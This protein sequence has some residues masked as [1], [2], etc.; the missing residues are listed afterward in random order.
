[1]K[2]RKKIFAALAACALVLT[3]CSNDSAEDTD[4]TQGDTQA[5]DT[6]TQ[7]EADAGEEIVIEHAYGETVIPGKPER[8]ATVAWANHEVPLALG[9][10]PVGMS[11]ATWGDDDDNGL[12]PWV[13]D[14][15]EELNAETPVLFDETDGLP[16]EEIADTNP[17]VI[18]ASYSGLT[19]EDYEQLSRIA[20][21]VAFPEV[22]WATTYEEMTRMNAKAMGM[23]EEGEAYLAELDEIVEETFAKYPELEGTTF[24][25]TAFGQDDMSSVGFY[26][27]H[28]TR[29]LFP[30]DNGMELPQVVADES[31]NTTQF[32]TKVS[33]EE[34][35]RFDDVELV[36]AYGSDDEA[37]NEELLKTLQADPLL[38]KM[39]AI[40]AGSVAFIGSDPLAASANPSPLSIPATLDEYLALLDGALKN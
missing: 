35:E 25:F 16:F 24:L 14:R 12:L 15:L 8:I 19:E 4:A 20:P 37:E 11:K 34:I 9:V 32:W 21:T 38:G 22:A 17:D 36:I 29:V 28:D 26:T 6:E 13:E 40:A 30:A 31:A 23:E 7:D 3:A 33:S 39:P 27:T 1:M 10:V 5:T 18:L 2:T